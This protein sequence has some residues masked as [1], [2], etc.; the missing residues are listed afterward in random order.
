MI[1]HHLYL[2]YL[3]YFNVKRDYYECHDVLEELWLDEQRYLFYQALIQVVVGLYHFRW[4]NRKGSIMLFEGAVNKLKP[5]IGDHYGIDVNKLYQDT[6]Q[7][8]Q[9]LRKFEQQPFEFYDLDIII[10]DQEL[11][12]LVDAI[13]HDMA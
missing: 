6:E 4:D 12:Q 9:K 5:Y 10:V 7:Y 2:L 3:Y 11:K 13:A 8:L 1:Y